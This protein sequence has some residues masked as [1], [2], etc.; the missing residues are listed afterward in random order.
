MEAS[1][2]TKQRISTRPAEDP[3]RPLEEG[4]RDQ[5]ADGPQGV[6]PHHP[7]MGELLPHCCGKRTVW[8]VGQLDGL[9]GAPLHKTDASKEIRSLATTALL[10]TFQSGPFR[11]LDVWRQTD[12][13]VSAQ[14]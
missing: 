3:E 14:V 7:G 8:E 4:T 13:R 6:E 10:R 9:Q 5:Y 1:H 2:Q 12:R 11:H